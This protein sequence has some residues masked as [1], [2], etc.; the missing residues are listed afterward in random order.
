MKKYLIL[1]MITACFACEK[2]M[3]DY[4]NAKPLSEVQV[5]TYDFLKQQ[6]GLYDTL[7]LLIDRVGLTDTLKSQQ[8][9]F[10]VPQDNS[11]T[12]AIRNVNFARERLGDAPN[13]TLD[14][15]PNKTWDSLLRRYIV[16]GIVT[17]DSLRYADGSDLTS[18]YGH[19]MNGKTGST[20]ASGAVGGGTAVLQYSDMNDSR[21][22][23][24]WSNALTQNVDIKS[25]NGW[26][27]I[28]ESRHVFGF[29][30]FVGKAYPRSLEPLQGPYLGYPI[31]I[32]GVLNAADYDEGPRLVAYKYNNANGGKAYRSDDP[33]TENCSQGDA[34]TSP[35]GNYNIGWTSDGDWVRYTV[36]IKEA[37]KYNV[38]LRIAGNG[39]GL[40]YLTIDDVRVCDDIPIQGTGGWQNWQ[41]AVGTA[42]LPEG[43]HLMKV[44]IK[45]ANLNLHRITFTKINP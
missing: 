13:W 8:V 34:L 9:T 10:F 21:F 22:S 18:L 19:K 12:T 16:R 14:S 24:D 20:N 45:K 40:I 11:I 44:Q 35:G 26:I 17:A 31:A 36:E 5:S 23:K 37:G 42:D 2:G 28:L 38:D 1:L 15:I 27:H 7:L 6:G 30:S 29:T 25:K 3:Q 4:R 41:S 39:G 32:P 43:K 33:G